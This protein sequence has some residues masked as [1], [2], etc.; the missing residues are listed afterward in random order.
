MQKTKKIISGLYLFCSFIILALL[1]FITLR[2]RNFISLDRYE[3]SYVET[4]GIKF[5]IFLMFF[6]LVMVLFKRILAYISEKNL[7]FLFMGIYVF[8]GIYLIF[9]VDAILRYDPLLVYESALSINQKD[10]SSLMVDGYI[11]QHIHQIGIVTLERLL[12]FFCKDIRFFYLVNLIAVCIT[13]YFLIKICQKWIKKSENRKYVILSLSLFIQQLFFVLFV[14]NVVIG[15]MFLVIALYNFIDYLEKRKIKDC[16]FFFASIVIASIIRS[17]FLIA[18][19][20]FSLL[21]FN[22]FLNTKKIREIILILLLFVS[23]SVTQSLIINNYENLSGVSLGKGIPKIAYITM[24]LQDYD[25]STRPAGWYNGFVDGVYYDLN[26]DSVATTEYS[27]NELH[28]RVNVFLKSPVLAVRF[29]YNKIVTT[30]SDPMFE[31]IW[32]GPLED[33]EQYTYTLFLQSLYNGKIAYKVIAIIENAFIA[34]IFICSFIHLI[35]IIHK[36][37]EMNSYEQFVYLLLVGTFVFHLFWET[38]SQYVYYCVLF[39]I[40]IAGNTFSEIISYN[41]QKNY[42]FGGK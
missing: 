14:Y 11:G 34:V 42:L 9:N 40:P 19:I 10:F 1:S 33:T 17:N 6:I 13:N 2:Y 18:M 35:D 25:G 29:F 4:N 5:I 3:T 39:L 16:L 27:I 41:K 26:Y 36:K 20:A 30:W 32:S 22:E 24:G 12:L 21:L 23:Y 31:S 28:R 8:L 15:L 38:K 37:E 7:I